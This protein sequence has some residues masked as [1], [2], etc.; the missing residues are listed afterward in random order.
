MEK[1]ES[2]LGGMASVNETHGQE[3]PCREGDIWVKPEVNHMEYWRKRAQAEG[4]KL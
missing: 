2:G 4:R 3:R 1:S